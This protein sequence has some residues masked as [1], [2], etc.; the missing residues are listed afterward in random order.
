MVGD[1][2]VD[3]QTARTAGMISAIVN[4]GFGAHDRD[5]Y[6]ADIYIDRMEEL[7]PLVF[8]DSQRDFQP[9]R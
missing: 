5:R 4:F 3:V 6:P 7:V 2:E 8:K 9:V 1:S